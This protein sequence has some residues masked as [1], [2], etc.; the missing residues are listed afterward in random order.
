MAYGHQYMLI[1]GS[2]YYPN[3]FKDFIKTFENLDEA[4]DLGRSRIEI[5]EFNDESSPLSD[6]FQI[7]DIY[8]EEIVY[9]SEEFED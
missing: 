3:K 6:W 1:A 7:F 9:D 8:N 2:D 5:D 4:I